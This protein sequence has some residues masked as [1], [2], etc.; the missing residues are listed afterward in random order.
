MR[1]FARGVRVAASLRRSKKT[2]S[3]SDVLKIKVASDAIDLTRCQFD[4]FF[5]R[6]KRVAVTRAAQR[7]ARQRDTDWYTRRR[8]G[9]AVVMWQQ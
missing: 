1:A 4:I 5:A 7:E 9:S 2:A 3:A 8:G 6:M